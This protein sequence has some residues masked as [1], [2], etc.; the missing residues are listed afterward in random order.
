MYIAVRLSKLGYYS[1]DPQKV[2]EAPINIVMDI[3]NFEG[4]QNKIDSLIMDKGR[5]E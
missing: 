5:E 1:G 2:L 4:V 3:I